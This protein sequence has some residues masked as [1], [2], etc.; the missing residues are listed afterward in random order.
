MTMQRKMT[1][2]AALEALRMVPWDFDGEKAHAE[3]DEILLQLIAD[4]Q[5]TRAYN[6]IEKQYT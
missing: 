6:A 1:K 5:I 4:D 2:K 3:A